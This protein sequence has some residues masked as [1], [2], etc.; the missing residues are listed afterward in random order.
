MRRLSFAVIGLLSSTVALGCSVDGTSRSTRPEGASSSPI[1]NG[2]LDPTGHPAVVAVIYQ[3]ASVGAA[4]T[5]TIFQID[6]ANKIGW[7]ITAGHCVSD[8]T[9]GAL[10][11]AKDLFVLEG[12][13]YN[14]STK[15][16]LVLDYQRM[17]GFN[18][19]DYDFAVLK[20]SNVTAT[21]PTLPL[22]T[23]AIDATLASGSTVQMVGYGQTATSGAGANNSKKYQINGKL[24]AAGGVPAVSALTL[25]SPFGPGT[26]CHGDSG[27]P[28]LF[29]SG[30]QQYVAAVTSVGDQNCQQFGIGAHITAATDFINTTIAGG[31]TTQT[32]AQCQ[33]G[34]T[35][36][37]AACDASVKACAADA[38]CNMLLSL[39]GC[40]SGDT[41]CEQT[42]FTNH[43]K[44]NAGTLYNAIIDCI[45]TTGCA[46]ECATDPL[47][48]GNKCGFTSSDMTCDSCLQASC[49]DAGAACSKDAQCT[50][51]ITTSPTPA[52]CDQN[53]A[54]TAFA[55]C[56]DTTCATACGGGAGGSSG[57]GGAGTGGTGAGAGPGA[58][59]T[60]AGAGPGTGGTGPGAGGA[61]PGA[62]GSGT[63]PGTGGSM[64]TGTGGMLSGTGGAAAAGA[65]SAGGATSTGKGGATSV[66]GSAAAGAGTGTGTG[67]GGTADASGDAPSS[68]SSGGCSVAEGSAVDPRGL[69]LALF[70]LAALVRRRRARLGTGS[71]FQTMP[72]PPGR[73]GARGIAHLGGGRVA[74]FNTEA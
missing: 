74:P 21:T 22:I 1:I 39:C 56:L 60:G 27:G 13:D 2:T 52:G 32:C 26:T 59:G 54:F 31:M 55:G 18:P 9:T 17:P 7:V 30:G 72:L 48:K 44:G 6:A 40:A 37:G 47:C 35:A 53:A 16:H 73:P 34:S 41:A 3:G 46:T 4:C 10:L 63:G 70:G 64:S 33:T 8:E 5:G 66:G 71:R 29:T 50:T 68:S 49:C 43:G 61:G 69:G 58:G 14:A 25:A 62:G 11:P 65:P 36:N 42:C 51:C 15:T 19:P 67:T 24:G 28:W 20:V 45:C 38:E 12:A 57:A 23:S